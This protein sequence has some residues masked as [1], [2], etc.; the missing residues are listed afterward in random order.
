MHTTKIPLILLNFSIHTFKKRRTKGSARV[1]WIFIDLYQ[2]AY[3]PMVFNICIHQYKKLNLLNES[4]NI[5]PNCLYFIILI[6]KR[7]I[8]QENYLIKFCYYYP[9][10]HNCFTWSEVPNS[11]SYNL[12]TR[13]CN[14]KIINKTNKM[15]CVVGNIE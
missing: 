2:G 4:P 13:K 14:I 9:A 6:Q 5:F 8:Q 15:R 12:N 3:R 10:R 11:S 1:T 7:K